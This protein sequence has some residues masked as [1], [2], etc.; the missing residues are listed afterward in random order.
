MFGDSTR[1]MRRLIRSSGKSLL[2][3]ALSIALPFSVCSA[4]DMNRVDRG[5]ALADL[6]SSSAV[7][8]AWRDY[9]LES[10]KPSFSWAIDDDSTARAPSLFERGRA[11]VTPASHFGSS[12]ENNPI[13][14]AMLSTK[15]G[16]SPLFVGANAPDLLPDLSPGFRRYVIAP[17]FT[18]RTGETSLVTVSAILAYQRLVGFGT[19]F[20]FQRE[21]FNDLGV[22][23][24]ANYQSSSGAGVRVDYATALADN[25]GWQFGYQNRVNMDAFSS[26]RSFFA[27]PGTFDIPASA[28]ASLDYALDSHLRLNAQ[29]E[30]VMYGQIPPFISSSL[31]KSLLSV[32]SS[33]AAPAFAWENLDVYS[34]GALWHDQDI[35]D[36]SIRYSTREQPLPTSALL[37]DALGATPSRYNVEIGYGHGFGVSSML[38]FAATYAPTQFVF[39]TP[40]NYN[41]DRNLGANQFQ[42]EA[43]W[44]THF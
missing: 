8:D 43:L 21:H 32:L 19:D 7:L 37:R 24:F 1:R 33:G 16:D 40:V 15:V 2:A 38:R 28:N 41:L 5:S 39:G 10:L 34:L 9:A 36:F 31:P 3:T 20:E 23:Q 29:I 11:R 12:V 27:Q 18:Q 14:V 13:H 17:S 42:F 22:T 30:R 25:L 44:T 4:N 26:Y 6:V 35:G